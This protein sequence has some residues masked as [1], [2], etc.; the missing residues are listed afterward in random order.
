MPIWV[1]GEK[2]FGRQK[3]AFAES[4]ISSRGDM[5]DRIIKEI[6]ND[7]L[8][9]A[10]PQNYFSV[11]ANDY[12]EVIDSIIKEVEDNVNKR[13]M[14]IHNAAQAESRERFHGGSSKENAR[15]AE[16]ARRRGKRW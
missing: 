14:S 9:N 5:H 4:A 12:R 2:Y 16:I 6:K 7:I 11:R 3:E 13:A 10:M 8:F 1:N 15:E